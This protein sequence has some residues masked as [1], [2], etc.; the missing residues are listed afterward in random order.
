[1]Y[2]YIEADEPDTKEKRAR[3]LRRFGADGRVVWQY[4]VSWRRLMMAWTCR[5]SDRNGGR[6]MSIRDVDMDDSSFLGYECSFPQ[7]RPPSL[8]WHKYRHTILLQIDL[9]ITGWVENYST[10][11][12]DM[13]PW[14]DLEGPEP[15]MLSCISTPIDNIVTIADWM[16]VDIFGVR[17]AESL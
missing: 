4:H 16:N 10:M 11:S 14:R 12:R 8:V 2:F 3:K 6:A 5:E 1:M 15:V 7:H 17:R 9:E 13:T